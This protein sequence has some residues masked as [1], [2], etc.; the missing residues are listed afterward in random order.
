MAAPRSGPVPR[1]LNLQHTT[2]ARCAPDPTLSLVPT[3]VCNAQPR[4]AGC[5]LGRRPLK[6]SS[7]VRCA[8][9]DGC[10]AVQTRV[11]GYREVSGLSDPW[12]GP[13]CA[14]GALQGCAVLRLVHAWPPRPSALGGCTHRQGQ[15][16][17][18]GAPRE[19]KFI[20]I[21]INLLPGAR[22]GAAARPGRRAP[23]PRG[24]CSRLRGVW[25]PFQYHG[26]VRSESDPESRFIR[27]G[28]RRIRRLRAGT[29]S[30]G[31]GPGPPV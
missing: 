24:A 3:Q 7:R 5:S 10:G 27:A 9:A 2:S 31:Q 29:G 19:N 25:N 30:R 8:H 6:L 4:S 28:R 15:A 12:P 11:L 21:C 13:S 18:A 16:G 14:A 17:A 26:A 1:D 20:F 23:A 22:R